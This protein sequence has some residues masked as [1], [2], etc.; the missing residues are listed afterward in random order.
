MVFLW[1][2]DVQNIRAKK[3]N[4]MVTNDKTCGDFK[5]A[6]PGG[7]RLTVRDS[8]TN[9][10][11]YKTTNKKQSSSEGSGVLRCN[12]WWSE[13][14]P[15]AVHILHIGTNDAV[16]KMSRFLTSY[17]NWIKSLQICY[18]HAEWSCPGQKCRLIMARQPNL[19]KHLGQMEADLLMMWT[20]K[21]IYLR[22]V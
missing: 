2:I 21:Y 9:W 22:K 4:D 15:C 16:S 11:W 7:T 17:F 14:L 20:M 12:N 8:I 18:T 1:N 10:R 19:V 6:W 3:N 13:I 5:Y